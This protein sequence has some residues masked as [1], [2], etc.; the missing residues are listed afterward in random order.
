MSPFEIHAVANQSIVFTD[1]S[2]MHGSL[3]ILL[4]V[5]A[6]SQ[7]GP[8][9]PPPP[10]VNGENSGGIVILQTRWKRWQSLVFETIRLYQQYGVELVDLATP[11]W[12]RHVLPACQH[13]IQRLPTDDNNGAYHVAF[14]AA[15][16]GT[17]ATLVVRECD[18]PRKKEKQQQQQQPTG[19]VAQ[20]VLS[21]VLQLLDVVRV[22]IDQVYGHSEA[23]LWSHPWRIQSDIYS[24]AHQQ[25]ILEDRNEQI[26]L[27]RFRNDIAW[28]TQCAYR[29]ESVAGMDTSWGDDSLG[30]SL[31]AL[32]AFDSRPMV[33]TP[34]YVWKLWFPHVTILFR[35][36]LHRRSLAHLPLSLLDNLL[37]IIPDQSLP[38]TKTN[39][40]KPD[41]PYETFQQIS[42][43][44]LVRPGSDNGD[45]DSDDDDDHEG[46]EPI[47]K[48][49]KVD[50]KDAELQSKAKAERF[51]TL[52]KSL[53]NKYDPITQVKTI[54]KLV[55]D[56]PHLGL[57][58]RFID[59]LRP[60]IF[61]PSAAD[62]LWTF[63]GSFVKDMLKHMDNNDDGNKDTDSDNEDLPQKPRQSL[64]HVA[65]LVTKVELFVATTTMIQLYCMVKYHMPRKI[66][67]RPLRDFYAV[68]Q[69]TLGLWVTDSATMPPDDYYRLFLLEGALQQVLRVCPLRKRKTG[70][71]TSAEEGTLTVTSL[72]EDVEASNSGGNNVGVQQTTLEPPKPA[73]QQVIV[74]EVGIFDE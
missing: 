52:M 17:T 48:G 59:L 51:V 16:V 46:Y 38:P 1:G 28:W 56:C 9:P 47:T 74:G 29:H 18:R 44:I 26:E 60:L 31:L 68:L 64:T 61:E 45:D 58:A 41:S 5:Y 22:F 36:T 15:V 65:T 34:N 23:W 30:V 21:H 35:S 40:R 25:G 10:G 3:C 72:D 24:T 8:P 50:A 7:C 57:Q 6:L 13:V 43:Q 39:S 11:L 69:N 32:V 37:R 62:A 49:E 42:N 55:H 71:D 12:D 73:K 63:I 14:L 19:Q 2:M 4:C 66:K 54:R 20:S 70:D 27:L 67:A 33:W 53:L